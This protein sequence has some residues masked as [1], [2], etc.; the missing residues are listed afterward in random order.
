MHPYSL[1]IHERPLTLVKFNYDGDFFLTCGKDGEVNLIRT[2]TCERVGTYNPPGEKAGAVFAVDVTMDS[3]YVV[4]AN[5]DGKLCFYT[6]QGEYVSAI[7]HGGVLKYVEWNLKPGDQNM[8][9]TCNDKFKSAAEGLVPN[10]IMIWSFD[11]PRR[12]LSIDDQLPMKATKVKW[13]AFDETLVSIF[14]EGTV[15]VWDSSDGR[16]LQ[17]IQ[18]HQMAITSMNFTEDR[19]IMATC[20]KDATAKLWTMDDY[21]CIKEYK[22]DRP[23]NDV[24]I[25]PLYCS[26]NNCKMHLLMGGGLDAKDVAVSGASGAFEAL[27]WH[28]VYEEEIGSV[29]GHIGPLNTM[30]WFRDGAGFV[31]G[32]EASLTAK[33]LQEEGLQVELDVPKAVLTDMDGSLELKNAS[34]M[35]QAKMQEVEVKIPC[36]LGY[37]LF[38][39]RGCVLRNTLYVISIAAFCG[40][41]TKT[42]MNAA[43]A[44]GKV[45][46]MQ[47]YL[48]RGVQGLVLALALWCTYCTVAGELQGVS[49]KHWVLRFLFYWIILYQIIPVSLYVCFE[50]IKLALAFQINKDPS[51]V[52]LRT[53][54]HA[55]ARTADLVEE[56][57]Q[58]NFVFS[59]KTGTLTENE[60]VFA[61]CCVGGRDLG[62]FRKGGKLDIQEEAVGVAEAKRVLADPADPLHAEALWF[63]LNLATNHSVQVE[64]ASNGKKIFEGSS[65]DEVAFVDAANAVGV[66]F[67][68][69]TRVAGTSNTEVVVKGPGPQEFTFTTVCEI[70]F[71][72]DRK[73]MSVIVKHIGEYWCLCKGADNIMGPLC[74]RPLD[75]ALGESLT[76]YSK[77]G[78]RTLVIAAKKM[79]L[80]F[81]EDWLSRWKDASLESEDREKKMAE[82]AAEVEHSLE[83]A[84]I[85]A[86]EDK[87]QDGVPEAIVSIKA[88]S[89]RFWVL[90]G[91]KTETAVEIAKSCR[92]FTPSMTLAYLVNC[93]SEQQAMSLLEEAKT[94]LRDVTDGGLVIDGTFVQQVLSSA[95]GRPTLYE[96]AMSSTCCVCCRLSPQQK[97]RLVELVKDMNKTGITLAVGDGANDVPMIQGA[98]VGIGIRGKEGNQAVQA[99]DVAISQFR[100]LVPLLYCHGRRAYRRVATFICYMFYKHTT[101]AVGDIFYAHQIGFVPQIAYAEWLNSAFASIICGLPVLVVVSWDTD[102]PDEVSVASPH[103]YVEGLQRMRFN[104]PL[105]VAWVLSAFYHGGV[106]WLVPNLTVGSVDVEDG[107]EFWYS[108]CISFCLVVIFVNLR[109]WMIAESP[110]SKE[111]VGIIFFSF[112]SLAVTLAVLAETPLGTDMMQPQIAGAMSAMF[113]EARYAAVLFLT[114]FLLLVDLAV[115]QAISYFHPY[116]LTAAKRKLWWSKRQKKDVPD[117]S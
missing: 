101:L 78:L 88:A 117:R 111:T 40:P 100:F 27:L 14:E 114:P 37:E 85:T 4:T 44:V 34:S 31:T 74:S 7:N 113:T 91:D 68:S 25:S 39:P 60:M 24:A 63:F 73:R 9:C 1:H 65:A 28:M 115:Y 43:Q 76:Q 17:L 46:N 109:L 80:S 108:S 48:N 16:Q 69:R 105:L 90:T 96:L 99:S 13:G 59:D 70:P 89:I 83:P 110:L 95:S 3:T 26:E 102:I 64:T 94:K 92:L 97:R 20:S 23:L 53:Q 32:G 61:H 15:I 36:K 30:A 116:P 22:T 82:I 21:E 81:T 58:V 56:M 55:S 5:A 45:S 72:S 2:E 6:F 77:L 47:V 49:E 38:V 84:G 86:I 98:H 52:D 18:A 33:H 93:S 19:M 104:A 57:G 12:I 107:D 41:H 106:S 87:L 29:K 50:I 54:Q 67:A 103:L 75:G 42:R 11:P 62:D 35:A 10:R 51:M 71:S 8:V 79:D 112:L 66:S